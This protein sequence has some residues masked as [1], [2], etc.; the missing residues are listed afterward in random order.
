MGFFTSFLLETE[1]TNSNN[2]RISRKMENLSTVNGLI[3][4]FSS[5]GRVEWWRLE[6]VNEWGH[7]VHMLVLEPRGL[8]ERLDV[9]DDAMIIIANKVSRFEWCRLLT[10][11]LRLEDQG[12]CGWLTPEE[13]LI[14]TMERGPGCEKCKSAT[15]V[16]TRG[17]LS[18]EGH[19]EG[20][21]SSAA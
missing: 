4:I 11:W 6:K 19:A 12:L 21:I 2:T 10:E 15:D 20:V 14:H 9:G 13:A 16:R 8:A 18:S 3:H 1:S 17:T 5:E 7:G